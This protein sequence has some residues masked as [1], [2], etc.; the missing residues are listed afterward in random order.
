MFQEG[1]CKDLIL[2]I[3]PLGRPKRHQQAHQGTELALILLGRYKGRLVLT[4][5]KKPQTFKGAKLLR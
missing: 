2:A 5:I 1:N 3:A 4:R